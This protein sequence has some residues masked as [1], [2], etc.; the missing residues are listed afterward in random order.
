M[1][2]LLTELDHYQLRLPRI[3]IKIDRDIQSRI[4]STKLDAE[5]LPKNGQTESGLAA[6]TPKT[7]S[8]VG[9]GI[10]AVAILNGKKTRLKVKE[11][12]ERVFAWHPESG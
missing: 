8:Q 3:P 10:V 6:E 7:V 5:G 1:R 2:R 12:A 11:L 9:L 4:A